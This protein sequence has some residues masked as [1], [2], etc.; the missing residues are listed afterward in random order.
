MPLSR[1]RRLFFRLL[2]LF[3]SHKADAELQRE[4]R[5]FRQ[6][7][8]WPMDLKLGARMLVKSPGLA[9][10]AVI[11]L[12]VA[13]GGGAAYLEVIHD[14]LRPTLPLADGDR[15]IGVVNWDVSNDAPDS[16]ALRDFA[17]WRDAATSIEY[18]GAYQPIERNLTTADG[19]TDV[20]KGVEISAAA[21]RLVPTP[22]LFG[23]PLVSDDEK[24]SADPVIVI[25]YQLWQTRFNGDPS[26]IGRPVR[27]GAA[28]RTIVGVM[29]DGFGF[30]VNQ[31]L[32]IPLQLHATAVK[33]GEGPEIRIFGRLAPNATTESAQAELASIASGV[34]AAEKD[35]NQHLR[36]LVKPYVESLLYA[37]VEGPASR[38]ILDAANVFFLFLLAVCG[39]N[40][41]T[42]V[43][44]RTATREGEITVR[45]ALGATRGRI[46]AQLFAEALVLTSLAAAVGLA[47]AAFVVRTVRRYLAAEGVQAPFWWNDA[48]STTTLLYVGGLAVLA[49]AIV[50]IV[51][52]LKATGDEMQ[53]RLKHAAAGGSGMKFGRVWTGVIVAQVALTVVFLLS[54]VSLAWNASVGQK[55]TA[56]LAFPAE[57][58]LSMRID[59]DRGEEG[60][61]FR[62]R[63]LE[64]Y[65]DIERRIEMDPGIAG[66]TYATRLPGSNQSEFW[67]ELQDME[68]S[69]RPASGPLW[70][71]SAGV[72]EDFFE[73]LNSAIVRGRPF[74]RSEVEQERAVAIV[75]E[76]FVKLVLGGRDPIGVHVRRQQMEEQSPAG[77]WLEIVGVA[78]DLTIA[79][80]KTTEDARLYQP[81]APGGATPISIIAR[82]KGDASAWSDRI[83]TL[84]ANTDPA[85]RLYEPRTLDEIDRGEAIAYQLAAR[86]AAIVSAV[87]LL[88]ATAGVYALMAFTL[89]RRTREIGIRIALGAAPSRIVRA[90]FSRAFTQVGLGV[91]IGCIPGTAVVAFGAPEVARGGGAALAFLATAAVCL[92]IMIIALGACVVPARRA[93]RVQPT[94]ALRA[95]A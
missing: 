44:A 71:G 54:G 72:S 41:A 4:A 10:V 32:W 25:G 35:T 18:L 83:R 61:A 79:S 46:V 29:P 70:V 76:S 39:A 5:S 38:M 56:K 65:R 45:T 40:V 16:R 42:L 81:V 17:A 69:I 50:G 33:R 2:T 19:R 90:V 73:T 36:P 27:V 9:V 52:A 31:S 82:V 94:D 3:R 91:V 13:I 95:D 6:L 21:F 87:A 48:L 75:D 51:P 11:A 89:A 59:M 84:A 62:P 23:R 85:V 12:A 47:F 80:G 1:A 88:L 86:G 55:G 63:F 34:S 43:F 53:G 49:A 37:D 26:V 22:P 77:P 57:Q 58:Y 28:T 8:G 15:I 78:R 64:R 14:Y 30:P 93:L 74:T 20:V 24:P 67:V 60:P 92:A 68:P 66:V 7:A